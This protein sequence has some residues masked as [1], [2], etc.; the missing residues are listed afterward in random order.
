LAVCFG[1]QLIY[2]MQTGFVKVNTSSLVK[3]EWNYKHD[4]EFLQ[5][6]LIANI[7]KNGQ[8]E[9]LIV[10]ELEGD[11]LEVVNGNH[12]FSALQTLGIEQCQ[13]YNLG[14]VD[15]KTAK[16]I[17]IETNESKFES[18]EIEL[19]ELLKEISDT[20]PIADML[21]TMPFTE[22]E[23]TGLIDQTNFD[24]NSL[25]AKKVQAEEKPKPLSIDADDN[26]KSLFHQYRKQHEGGC[27]S[28]QFLLALLEC[29]KFNYNQ[30]ETLEPLDPQAV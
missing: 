9:N 2:I 12:R 16:R 19:S 27:S 29:Y 23:L 21:D 6:R 8:I 26:L 18:N 24:W 15:E 10:R 5:E 11:K 25:K 20:T 22:V 1:A 28:E 7:K 3:A 4:N 17:A 13:V 14:K 30:S